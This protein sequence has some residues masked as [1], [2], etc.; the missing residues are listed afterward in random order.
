[1]IP[2]R[3]DIAALADLRKRHHWKLSAWERDYMTLHED[4]LALEKDR[5]YWRA[6]FFAFAAKVRAKRLRIERANDVA[7]EQ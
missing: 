5:N 4:Y 2:A 3:D 1:M 6:Q 7:A